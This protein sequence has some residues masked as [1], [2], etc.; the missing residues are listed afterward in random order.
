MC[1]T[2]VASEW[3]LASPKWTKIATTV[4]SFIAAPAS[5]DGCNET[6]RFFGLCPLQH[7]HMSHECICG[8]PHKTLAEPIL[9]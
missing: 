9:T 2:F 1:D 8:I 3:T 4:K 7:V 6:E 5:F